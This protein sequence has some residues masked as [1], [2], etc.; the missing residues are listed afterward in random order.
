MI[1]MHASLGEPNPATSRN[2][3][4]A[5]LSSPGLASIEPQNAVQSS[6]AVAQMYIY[7]YIYIYILA[8]F[9]YY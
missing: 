4:A 5:R 7:I 9:T 6:G 3:P 8:I 2:W 1:L